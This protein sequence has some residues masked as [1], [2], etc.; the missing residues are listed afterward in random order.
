MHSEET[1]RLQ[2]QQNKRQVRIKISGNQKKHAG[3]RRF[4]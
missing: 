3:F 1:D 4:F 2:K